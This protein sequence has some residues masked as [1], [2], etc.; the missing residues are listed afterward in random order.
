[1]RVIGGFYRSRLIDMPKGVE[2]RPTQDKVREAIFNILGD[3]SGKAVLDLF[4]GSGAFGIESLSRGASRATFVENNIR[5]VQT[6]ENN[7]ENLQIPSSH[8]DIMKRSALR[9]IYDLE[10]EG[11]KYDIVFM[12][13]PYHKD[14][15]KNCLINLD[16]CDIL[17]Q[18]ATVVVEHYKLDE[19]DFD[20]E[21]LVS[22][23]EREYG[24]TV[25]TFLKRH[26]ENI[27]S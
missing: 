14:L 9:A 6:I 13:P 2:M 23:K 4:S 17:S 21:T 22:D 25:I 19:L 16:S 15:A 8:Y 27:D 1:M 24:D 10:G 20:L 12:D 18:F 3:I 7:L 5:C 11:S 26:A